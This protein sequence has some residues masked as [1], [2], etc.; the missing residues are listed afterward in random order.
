MARI[1]EP[2][3]P[4]ASLPRRQILIGAGAAALSACSPRSSMT[5]AHT[6]PLDMKQLNREVGEIAARLVPGVLGV[7]LRNLD[8]GEVW[9]LN[10]ARRFPL[11]SVF[12]A[13][14]A[15]AALAEA[16]A[17]RL[18]LDERLVLKEMD[19]SPPHS[20]IAE[21]WPRRADYTVRELLLAALTESD[22][23]AADVLM[24]RIGGP[25]AVTAWLVGKD[26]EEIRVDRYERELQTEMLG[27][28]PFR[29]SWRS[30]AAFGQALATVPPAQQRQALAAYLADPRDTATPRGALHFLDLLDDGELLGAAA[31][32]VLLQAMSATRSG[33]QRLGAGLPKGSHFVHKTGA[34]R[35]VQGVTSVLND[36]GVATLPDQRRYA[37]AA[38]LD[39][40]T[41]PP[42]T[43]EA[44]L[45]EV[46]RAL[47]RG[48]GRGGSARRLINL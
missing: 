19:L 6:P 12:K 3:Q 10:G 4:M 48:V 46:A 27:L 43:C 14:L 35:V 31:Q 41:A 22:N 7:G 24:A 11:Q 1:E 25:G 29:P 8:S 20:P 36:I 9:T 30:E 16:E 39:G 17:G 44:A 13:P 38:F 2:P 33:A 23:T 47:V 37:M 40:A 5:V 34:G 15:A 45:A 18:S 26:I 21:A 32:R 28:S 42:A